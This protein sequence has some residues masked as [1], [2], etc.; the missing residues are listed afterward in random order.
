MNKDILY[1]LKN[2]VSNEYLNIDVLGFISDNFNS[3]FPIQY[4]V[5]DNF[6]NKDLYKSFENEMLKNIDFDIIDKRTNSFISNKSI[7]LNNKSFLK[8]Y[9]FFI[10]KDFEIFLSIIFKRHLKRYKKLD[11][12]R[13]EELTNIKNSWVVQIYEKWDFMD[14]HTDISKDLNRD[15]CILK[16]WYE[17]WD[18]CI[19]T[20][21]DE[22]GA[23]IY[24]I[25][26]SNDL[27]N[28]NNWW[29]LE[30]WKIL[31]WDINVYNKIKPLRNRLVF[32]KSS[33]ASYH[34]VSKL[35]KEWD[36]RITIQDLLFDK[37]SEIW[38]E[39]LP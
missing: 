17:E 23:F 35:L 38:N 30:L 27:W 7:L 6:I 34:R 5:M 12:K 37:Y 25:Y 31:N 15:E 14:W 10:S 20:E 33:N 2:I 26:N 4:Y 39:I 8:I 29:N 11:S 21:F 36:Y 3:R 22:V 16:W 32:I 24:Y 1:N 28:Y 19:V 9:N 13:I 18:K